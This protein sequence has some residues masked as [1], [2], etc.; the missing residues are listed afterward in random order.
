M[1]S[2]WSNNLRSA[3]GSGLLLILCD[4][5][6]PSARCA[7][8][9]VDKVQ[10]R[11]ALRARQNSSL[12]NSEVAFRM[13]TSTASRQSKRRRRTLRAVAERVEDGRT[14]DHVANI[15]ALATLESIRTTGYA[16]VSSLLFPDAAGLSAISAELE[17]LLKTNKANKALHTGRLA[18]NLPAKACKATLRAVLS[19]PVQAVLGAYLFG[20]EAGWL[21]I[22]AQTI[23]VPPMSEVQKFHRDHQ[24]GLGF[25]LVLALS[26]E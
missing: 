7:W 2:F 23:S 25:S 22:G 9:D 16:D 15:A 18:A 20:G 13:R 4:E 17:A 19:A 11:A 1:R 8:E 26:G 21:L 10:Q 3:C 12:A 24:H 6:A 5:L 14:F